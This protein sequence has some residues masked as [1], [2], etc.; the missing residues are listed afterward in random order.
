[1][2]EKD[3]KQNLKTLRGRLGLTQEE[4][5]EKIGL[6]RNAYRALEAGPTHIISPHVYSLAKLTG[7]SVESLLLGFEPSPLPDAI[8]MEND[9]LRDQ[10]KAQR[11]DY[12][13]KL[14]QKNEALASK[15]ELIR[16]KDRT[17]KVQEE[18]IAML[19]QK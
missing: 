17:I 14:A 7:I 16:S 1:M 6:N 9:H 15:D 12:E 10:I 4:M 13:M 5:G 19:R 3:L 18:M 2:D 8:L 11:D